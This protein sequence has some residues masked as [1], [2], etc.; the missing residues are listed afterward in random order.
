[1]LFRS[2]VIIS[3]NASRAITNEDLLVK[4]AEEIGFQV[5]IL[6]PD[7]TTELARIYKVLNSSEVMIGVHGAAM[8]H[9]LFMKPGSVFIQVI[10]LGTYMILGII[11]RVPH[12]LKRERERKKMWWR[13]SPHSTQKGLHPLR[14]VC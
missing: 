13:Y 4:M 10:P 12:F 5:E 3:R 6:R 14:G 2:L 1:M 7:K 11:P 9:F 8:T